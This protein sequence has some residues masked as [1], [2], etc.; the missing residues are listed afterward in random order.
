MQCGPI[1]RISGRYGAG[2]V[3]KQI[4]APF[5]VTI[6]IDRRAIRI[7]EITTISRV[8]PN[9]RPAAVVEPAPL[10]MI[11]VGVHAASLSQ[12]HDIAGECKYMV[13]FITQRPV[14]ELNR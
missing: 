4:I 13:G 1:F 6:L 5:S 10:R 3:Y 11:F 12:L 9:R 2:K 14:V 8:I 7:P